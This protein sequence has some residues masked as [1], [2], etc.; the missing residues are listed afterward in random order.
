MLPLH[1]TECWEVSL[2]D[3]NER[4]LTRFSFSHL[5]VA[6]II[7]LS[8]L[9][10]GIL[11]PT[12]PLQSV[13]HAEAPPLEIEQNATVDY[14]DSG[15][16]ITYEAYVTNKG[17]EPLTGVLITDVLPSGA[18]LLYFSDPDESGWLSSQ[19]E[20]EAGNLV[21][22]LSPKPLNS[23]QKATLVYV[24]SV[25]WQNI[26]S[27][28]LDKGLPVASAEGWTQTAVEDAV[29]VSVPID[30]SQAPTVTPTSTGTPTARP[31]ATASATPESTTTST[32]VHTPS[33]GPQMTRTEI[34]S[35]AASSE[36]TPPTLISTP[37]AGAEGVTA[38]I[39]P[40]VMLIALI[41][42]ILL[43]VVLWLAAKKR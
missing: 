36:T 37:A 39:P 19:R 35:T 20:T 17:A 32:A 9:V 1:L 2:L 16:Q 31:T 10:Y 22:W 7:V 42:V 43:V 38:G 24:V 18:N 15:P 29:A 11:D 14:T 21:L 30:Q 8:F 40:F 3:S 12:T 4:S 25:P 13:T 6:A 26:E 28:E 33:P 34:V 41:V 5:V 27:A 23:G